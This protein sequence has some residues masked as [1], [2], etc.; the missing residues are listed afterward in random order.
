[1]EN[2]DALSSPP[3]LLLSGTL[4]F[5]MEELRRSHLHCYQDWTWCPFPPAKWGHHA[6]VMAWAPQHFPGP[7]FQLPWKTDNVLS[8]APTSATRLDWWGG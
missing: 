1:M 2:P 8:N 7:N 5:G 3:P 4:C 6:G